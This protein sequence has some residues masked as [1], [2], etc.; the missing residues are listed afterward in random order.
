MQHIGLI[1]K[2]HFPATLTP[3]DTKTGTGANILFQATASYY[4]YQIAKDWSI[5]QIDLNSFN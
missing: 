1:C 4:S 5:I 2:R 3:T